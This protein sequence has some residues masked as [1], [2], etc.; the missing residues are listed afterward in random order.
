M[1]NRLWAYVKKQLVADTPNEISA[2]LDCGQ[3]TCAADRFRN[4]PVRLA[5]ARALDAE[6]AARHAPLRG[7]PA[8]D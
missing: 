5:H 3:I 1:L 4:C 6:E 2:C 7:A 8:E